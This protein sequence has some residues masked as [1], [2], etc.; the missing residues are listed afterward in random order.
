M[1]GLNTNTYFYFPLN[2]WDKAIEYRAGFLPNYA[3]FNGTSSYISYPSSSDWSNILINGT[4]SYTVDC[5]VKSTYSASEY[6]V[7]WGNFDEITNGVGLM[8]S[9]IAGKYVLYT[10]YVANVTQV[11]SASAYIDDEWH[12]IICYRDTTTLSI[13]VDDTVTQDTGVV[14]DTTPGEVAY[15]G[16]SDS[17]GTNNLVGSV[18]SL[19]I[20]EPLFSGSFFATHG[21]ILPTLP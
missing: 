18:G 12:H 20:S 10:S 5:W 15:I 17:L 1:S 8:H 4:D 21:R 3:E 16:K 6:R 2:S 14:R 19:T 13:S 7:V 11:E 9:E